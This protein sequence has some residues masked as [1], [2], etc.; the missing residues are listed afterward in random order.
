MKNGIIAGAVV[1]AVAVGFFGGT[2]YQSSKT[3]S[4]GGQFAQGNF[5][6][7]GNAQGQGGV[8]AGQIVA[9]DSN[10]ITV[11]MRD[12]SSKIVFLSASTKVSKS[13][14]GSAADLAQQKEVTITGT[15]NADGSITAQSIQIRP[16]M[17]SP[18]PSASPVAH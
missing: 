6:R 18:S 12:G 4:L 2:K 11:Q 10:S 5:R 13:V 1:V 15:A 7:A 8:V 9:H 17:P 16:A 3:A 14:D